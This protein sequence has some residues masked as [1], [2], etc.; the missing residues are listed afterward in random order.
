MTILEASVSRFSLT[1]D[2]CDTITVMVDNADNPWGRR[3]F[4]ALNF[5]LYVESA[6]AVNPYERFGVED[7]RPDAPDRPDMP[8]VADRFV[9]GVLGKLQAAGY[10]T[11]RTVLH[12]TSSQ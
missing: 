8:D 6:Y 11:A 10:V 4:D 5:A 9:S 2:A 1:V 7:F 3:L 12:E